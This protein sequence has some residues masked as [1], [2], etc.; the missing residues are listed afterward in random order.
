MR[1][2]DSER[3][4]IRSVHAPVK[5]RTNEEHDAKV[6]SFLRAKSGATLGELVEELATRCGGKRGVSTSIGRLRD[7]GRVRFEPEQRLHPQMGRMVG[8]YLAAD[9]PVE[10]QHR[11]AAGAASAFDSGG[12]E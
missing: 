9:G 1:M 8:L 11:E 12:A 2:R 6:L 5:E 7:Q 10:E 3:L 4:A